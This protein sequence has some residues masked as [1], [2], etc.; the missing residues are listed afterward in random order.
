MK[1]MNKAEMIKAI[2]DKTEVKKKDVEAVVN[3]LP[4]VITAALIAGDK[5]ALNGLG[6]FETVEVAEKTGIIALGDRKG[7][8]YVVP[9]HTAPKFKISKNLKEILKNKAE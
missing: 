5:V 8:T 1:N 4:E 2:A 7:E 6:T 3:A 9:K